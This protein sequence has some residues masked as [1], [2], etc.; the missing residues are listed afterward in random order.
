MT[1]IPVR[2]GSRG[3]SRTVGLSGEPAT[4]RV[5]APSMGGPPS[6]GSPIP[7]QTR[8]SHPSPT[9][10]SRGR[11]SKRDGHRGGVDAAGALRG[12]RPRPRRGGPRARGP[13]HLARGQTDA[14]ELVPADTLD[15]SHDEQR[16]F[17]FERAAVLEREPGADRAPESSW[18]V[19][20]L[21][22]HGERFVAP[23][24]DAGDVVGSDLVAHPGDGREVALLD[25]PRPADAPARRGRGS[26]RRRRAPSRAA[27]PASPGSRWRRWRSA[28]SAGGRPRGGAGR[29]AAPCA[30]APA[31][32]AGRRARPSGRAGRPRRAGRSP[33]SRSCSP[34]RPACRGVPRADGLGVAGE[35]AP[36][37]D[38]RVVARV[39]EVAVERPQAAHEALGV[40]GDGLGHVAAGW[41]DGA[42]GGHRALVAAE[43][44]HP[45]R[46]FV[47]GGQRRGEPGRVALFGGQLAASS[48]RTRA[49][50]RPSATSS[51]PAAR[52]RIP[53]PGRTRR[54]SCPCR[55]SPRAP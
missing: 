36:P 23:P 22:Q 45:A 38:G 32:P 54:R 30:R 46:A 1:E 37:R 31:V 25:R 50:P 24:L 7:F 21:L 52:R 18:H 29:R 3:T 39:G 11:P 53:C 14:G 12:P 4:G 2:M 27:P 15:T 55:C 49:A 40:G 28:R 48:T 33:A 16:T 26:G 19:P 35:R 6:S 41:G 17:G 20:E 47:E 10:I 43:G 34:A 9:G 51:R 42:D 8:P 13:A 5:T 44:L